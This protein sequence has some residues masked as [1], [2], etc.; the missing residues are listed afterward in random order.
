[1]SGHQKDIENW[2]NDLQGD[3]DRL[4]NAVRRFQQASRANESSQDIDD[5]R[6]RVVAT[7]Q[8]MPALRQP[9]RTSSNDDPIFTPQV[10]AE[11]WGCTKRH[12]TH[13]AATGQLRAF[14]VGTLYRFTTAAVLD[15]ERRRREQAG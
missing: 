15:F 8:G 14:R 10:L 7:V 2:L 6:W 12:V 3:V 13:L 11:R 5:A 1:M 9:E 4:V